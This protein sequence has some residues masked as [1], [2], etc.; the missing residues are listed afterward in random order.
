MLVLVLGAAAALF[1]TLSAT[2]A[3]RPA[4]APLGH[5][6]ATAPAIPLQDGLPAVRYARTHLPPAWP[7]PLPY[8]VLIADQQNDRLLEVA[9]NKRILWQYPPSGRAHS[10][11]GVPGDDAF[12]PPTAGAS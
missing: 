4:S 9:P 11:S 1:Y 10:P 7:G 6:P 2:A 8:P 12:F 5:A 3:P